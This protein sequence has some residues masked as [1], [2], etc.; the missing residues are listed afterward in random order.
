MCDAQNSSIHSAFNTNSLH[1]DSAQVSYNIL[2]C[3]CDGLHC[4]ACACG[5]DCFANVRER[6]RVGVY[7]SRFTVNRVCV[8]NAFAL[9]SDG[10]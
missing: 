6:Q 9:V 4:D 10:N 5:F 7:A 3:M 2:V 1:I 8:L